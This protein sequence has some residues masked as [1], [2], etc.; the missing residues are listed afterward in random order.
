[1][2]LINNSASI[3]YGNSQFN[4]IGL[5]PMSSTPSGVDGLYIAGTSG[6]KTS[7]GLNSFVN[8]FLYNYSNNHTGSNGVHLDLGASSN[9]FYGLD[10]E[11][12]GT[13]FYVNGTSSQPTQGALVSGGYLAGITTAIQTTANTFGISCRD[14]TCGLPTSGVIINEGGA[15]TASAGYNSYNNIQLYNNTATITVGS[16]IFTGFGGG[17]AFFNNQGVS[18]QNGNGSTKTFTINHNLAT[19]TSGSPR[20]SMVNVNGNLGPYTWTI[21]GKQISV[22]FVTAPP[23]GTANV[24]MNWSAGI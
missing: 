19:L 24:I 2:A 10:C 8:C 20:Y 7:I 23:K 14:L 11:R 22:S 16:G 3:N 6:Q 4:E 18:T 9:F 21:S 5:A 1:M 17:P 12:F 15:L 13:A